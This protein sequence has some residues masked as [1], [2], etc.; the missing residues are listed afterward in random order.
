MELQ[1]VSRHQSTHSVEEVMHELEMKH[2][3]QEVVMGRVLNE[4]QRGFAVGI[5]GTTSGGCI[6]DTT[7]CDRRCRVLPAQCMQSIDCTA[8]RCTAAILCQE[9]AVA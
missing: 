8:H 5:A 1:P 7:S 4:M 6:F 9:H 3:S 2:A